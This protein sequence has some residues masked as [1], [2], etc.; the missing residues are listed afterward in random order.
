MFYYNI[1]LPKPWWTLLTYTSEKEIGP[2]CRV[3]VPLGRSHTVGIVI[4]KTEATKATFDLRGIEEVLDHTPPVDSVNASLINW[5][6]ATYF[7]SLG[8]AA[9]TLMPSNFFSKKAIYEKNKIFYDKK[10]FFLSHDKKFQCKTFYLPNKKIRFEKYKSLLENLC[11]KSIEES[12]TALIAFPRLDQAK[13][14]WNTLPDEL[15]KCGVYWKASAGFKCYKETL[16][17]KFRFV[18]GTISCIIAPLENLSIC[19]AEDEANPAWY[20]DEALYYNGRTLLMAKAR[21]A[22]SLLVLAGAMP[23][24]NSFLTLKNNLNNGIASDDISFISSHIARKTQIDGVRVG[25]TVSKPLVAT[26]K[27]ELSKGNFAFWILDRKNYASETECLDCG[28]IPVCKRCGT[29][30][31]VINQDWLKCPN[32]GTMAKHEKFCPNCGGVFFQA[33]KPGLYA[34]H[35]ALKKQFK[36][37]TSKI[38][39]AQEPNPDDAKE[40]PF[41]KASDLKKQFPKG[42]IILGTRKILDLTE[43]LAPTLISYIDLENLYRHD[44][45]TNNFVAYF[46]IYNSYFDSQVKPKIIIQTSHPLVG[47]QKTLVSGYNFFLSDELSRR[48]EWEMPPFVY[49]VVIRSDKG[50]AEKIEAQLVEQG[51]D[52]FAENDVVYCKT[53]KLTQL[54]SHLEEFFDIRNKCKN[55]PKIQIFLE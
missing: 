11:S 1:A 30:L 54:R 10:E 18:V 53:T 15:K 3:V 2:F 26:T 39:L 17:G 33:E 36:Q 4:E 21:F 35:E 32:C 45:H 41:P 19:I 50:L 22:K 52:A 8:L 7:V 46:T 13:K 42:A 27:A 44:D 12:G 37:Y 23:S 28:Y 43:E 40:A 34:L 29:T 6:A 31:K 51:F 55:Y 25:L 9:K 48:K 16:S 5:F 20:S 47:W 49:T 38:F 24:L 14:F